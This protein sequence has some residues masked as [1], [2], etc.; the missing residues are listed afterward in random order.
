MLMAVEQPAIAAVVARL[1]DPEIHL[2]AYG[3]VVFPIAL[4]IEAPIISLLSAST[5]LS[6]DRA[7]YLSLRRFTHR[8]GAILTAI[9]LLIALTPLFDLLVRGVLGVPDTVADEARIGLIL[10]LPWSWAIASRRTGQGVLIRYGY[11]RWV[12]VGTG[13]R[14]LVSVLVLGTGF[15]L[16]VRGVVAATSALS[17]G[18]L[19]EAAVVGAVVARVRPR[20]LALDDP[21]REPLRGRA[22]RE[23][24]IPL[25][26]M[27]LVALVI[28]PVGTSALSRM[29]QVY[30]SLALWPVLVG[31]AFFFQA[32]GISFNEVVV[33]L[34]GRPGADKSIK[35]FAMWLLVLTIALPSLLAF[36]PLSGPWFRSVIGLDEKLATMATYAL[37]IVVP[38]PATRV[39]QSWFQG[40]LVTRRKT[41]GISE[42]VFIFALV[43]ASVMVS[44]VL[45][46]TVPGI[47]VG[48]AGFALG[49]FA[50]TIWLAYRASTTA[51]E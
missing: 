18:V 2:A 20:H 40:L 34:I 48:L 15:A 50:Q 36:T 3:S 6:R 13:L 11:G 43:C 14:L 28:Q 44:G 19:A 9:H 4:V 38:V 26:L 32:L 12:S 1:Q 46:Q 30:D 42:A 29:P 45:M 8:T 17:I 22:F 24:Y 49:R 35:R 7:S 31:L 10:L 41:R 23:F 37:M 25:A 16:G 33:A 51:P 47:Y 5:E 39:L 27:P 21:D